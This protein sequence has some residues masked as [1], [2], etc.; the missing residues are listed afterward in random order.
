[1]GFE[2]NH[3]IAGQSEC[4]FPISLSLFASLRFKWFRLEVVYGAR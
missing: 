3:A 1:M 2:E 4:I